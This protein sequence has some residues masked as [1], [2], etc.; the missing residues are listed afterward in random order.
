MTLKIS[1]LRACAVCLQHKENEGSKRGNQRKH[2]LGVCERERVGVC[3]RERASER[4]RAR[5]Q[6][7]QYNQCAAR[8]I[9]MSRE[10]VLS[11]SVPVM[12][13]VHDFSASKDSVG[14][15]ANSKISE[16]MVAVVGSLYIR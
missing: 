5:E 8:T 6:H 1:P 12:R 10:Y 11:E 14:S 3:E 15:S 7:N 16:A 9:A 4:V 13:R 2:E